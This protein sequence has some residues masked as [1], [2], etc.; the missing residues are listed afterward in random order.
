MECAAEA[1]R[2]ADVPSRSAS[3]SCEGDKF[4][5]ICRY[6]LIPLANGSGG[7]VD[8]LPGRAAA[9][10][11]PTAHLADLRWND[12]R[13][14]EPPG[15]P[16]PQRA[17]GRTHRGGIVM[18]NRLTHSARSYITLFLVGISVGCI[19]RLADFSPADTW[20]SVSS[21]QTCLGFWI[22]TNTIL[23]LLST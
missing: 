3:G 7:S 8:A 19:C 1:A 2:G 10:A 14:A 15:N 6:A 20:W 4:Q 22:I 18:N 16:T 11:H 21:I 23:V 9:K 17:A 13:R 5:G 12:E